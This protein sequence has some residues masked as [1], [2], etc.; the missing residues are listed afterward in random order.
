MSKS[1]KESIVLFAL[2]LADTPVT[3]GD[4]AFRSKVSYNT[5]KKIVQNDFRVDVVGKNPARYYL[6]TPEVLQ[7][8]VIQLP[9]ETPK[10][11]WV[12]WTAKVAPKVHQLIRI[13]KSN[14]SETVKKQGIV[15]ETLGS[16]FI[17]LGK[18]LQSN[19]S[20]PDW[21]SLI[22]GNEND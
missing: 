20:K 3:I 21:Y 5:V 11:G 13:D 1:S 14:D 2:A 12:A 8:Q 16:N 10:E 15:V 18:A 9:T 19:A 4:L 17:L 22:G 7:E 6:A